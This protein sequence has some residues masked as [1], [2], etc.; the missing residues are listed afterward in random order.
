MLTFSGG[1]GEDIHVAAIF[2]FEAFA[3]DDDE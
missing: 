2:D 3:R 1:C